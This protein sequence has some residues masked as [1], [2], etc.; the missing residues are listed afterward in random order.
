MQSI[1]E[2]GTVANIAMLAVATGALALGGLSSITS[3]VRGVGGQKSALM[4]LFLLV[5][6]VLLLSGSV[7]VGYFPL[8]ESLKVRKLARLQKP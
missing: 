5:L 7:L 6:G 8:R 2:K 3:A 1:K 4:I